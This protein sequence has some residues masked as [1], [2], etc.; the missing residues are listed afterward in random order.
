MEELMIQIIAIAIFLLFPVWRIYGKAGLNPA[1]SL[2]VLI[3]W[4][5]IL[6]CGLIL[7]FSKW[8]AQAAGDN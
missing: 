2:T 7:V 5:G 8:Q 3:P 6:V 1:M 4:I